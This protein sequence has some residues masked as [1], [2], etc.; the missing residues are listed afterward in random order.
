VLTECKLVQPPWK[1]AWKFLKKL[2]SEPP[3][4]PEILPGCIFKRKEISISKTHLH[5]RI[6]CRTVHNSQDMQSTLVLIDE[7]TEKKWYVYTMQYYSGIKKKEIL[8][9]VAT[10]LSLEDMMLSET[11]QAQKDKYCVFLLITWK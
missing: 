1:R 5:S 7:W 11:S 3:Y 8:T 6:Y 10:W 4:D 9:F 2:E